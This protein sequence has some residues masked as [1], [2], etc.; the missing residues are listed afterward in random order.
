MT[1]PSSREVPPLDSGSYLL[2]GLTHSPLSVALA[3]PLGGPTWHSSHHGHS[4]NQNSDTCPKGGHV[5]FCYS[6]FGIS[7]VFRTQFLVWTSHFLTV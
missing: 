7:G 4:Q 2:K 1:L 3:C 5:A 6:R